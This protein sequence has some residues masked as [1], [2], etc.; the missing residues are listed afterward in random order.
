MS[1]MQRSTGLRR[2]SHGSTTRRSP[3]QSPYVDQVTLPPDSELPPALAEFFEA[4]GRPGTQARAARL[5]ELGLNTDGDLER[6]LG[7]RIVEAASTVST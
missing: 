4:F 5:T 1:S 6:N 7:R 3:A 2:A